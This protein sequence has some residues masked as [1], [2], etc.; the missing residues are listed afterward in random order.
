MND[1]IFAALQYFNE[2]ITATTVIIATSLLFYNLS[3]SINDRVVRASSVVLGCV[4][5]AYV[6]NVFTALGLNNPNAHIEAWLRFQWIGIAFTPAALFHLSDALL[7]TTGVISRGRRRRVVRLLYLYGV[8]FL[9]TAA[10]SDL[11]IHSAVT[12]PL[13]TMRPGPLLSLY[14]I[15]FVLTVGVSFNNVLRARER[16]RTTVTHRRMTYLLFTFLMPA[17]GIFPYSL[18]FPP[19][20][21][22]TL[23]VQLLINVG[24]IGIALMLAFMAYPLAFFGQNKPDRVIKSELMRFMLRGPLTAIVVLTIILFIPAITRFLGL[25]GVEFLPFL[26][27]AAVLLVQWGIALA[28]PLLDRG[29]VYAGD[30]DQARQLQDLSEHLLTQTDARQQLEAILAATCDYL[31]VDSAFV[32]AIDADGTHLESMVG[33]LLPSQTWLSSPEFLALAE[34][35][36]PDAPLPEGFE[37]RG[38]LLI[39]QSFWLVPLRSARPNGHAN[40][41]I[42]LMGVW[43]RSPQPDLL[44]E[45]R[46]VFQALYRRA[47]RVLDDSRL[48]AD[49]FAAL[50]GLLPEI[51]AVQ[52]LPGS[53]RY[54]DAPALAQPIPDMA[55][56]PDFIDL[57]R[58]ALRDYWGGPRLTESRLLQLNVVRQA[59]SENE[60]SPARAV[61]AVL[62]KAIESL[63]P[64]GT[65]QRLTTNEW[66]LYNVLDMRFVQGQKVLDVADKLAMSEAN[67]HRKQ[68]V[69]IEQVAQRVAAM[70]QDAAGDAGEADKV[71]P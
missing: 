39:G 32:V 51:N 2:A 44:A 22:Y 15:Y 54:G 42:G 45:E 43:A 70:E 16:C 4:M 53:A 65:G 31:R 67:V 5:A 7:E 40:K 56:Q 49:I 33:S 38:D 35:D 36:D 41:L 62:S 21:N 20:P 9:L 30:Q 3:H 52:Q 71:T 57:I 48:Q 26:A 34:R 8:A 10:G 18:L 63:R 37:A 60:G 6:G 27:V 29:L 19:S 66:T 55:A 46:T 13:P 24:N 68:R 14:L 28:L 23:W 69:A 25:P 58:D 47:A 61:R 64:A 17:V 11:I 59:L 12:H 50:K 1:V